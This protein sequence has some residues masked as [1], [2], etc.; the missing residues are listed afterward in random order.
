MHEEIKTLKKIRKLIGWSIK[1]LSK[2]TR[3]S[4]NVILQLEKGE[5]LRNG[6]DFVW[7]II[8][9][10][11][12]ESELRGPL[13]KNKKYD[14][15]VEDD[16]I[17][18]N[19]YSPNL[20]QGERKWLFSEEWLQKNTKRYRSLKSKSPSSEEI[21][22]AITGLENQSYDIQ[23]NNLRKEVNQGHD[24]ISIVNKLRFFRKETD[25]RL[26][27][28]IALA[29]TM[30][31][32]IP[33][34]RRKKYF[35]NGFQPNYNHKACNWL[36]IFDKT[37]NTKGKYATNGGEFFI[38]SLGYFLDYINHDLK[39]IMEWDEEHHFD[40]N[41]NLAERDLIRQQT[42]EKLFPDYKELVGQI[43]TGS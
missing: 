22:A 39:I 37:N 4:C 42:I 26:S 33:D 28:A 32:S 16:K 43:W 14:R 7:A 6:N 5:T 3:L 1:D 31:R 36:E 9:A 23:P 34:A 13:K 29:K 11:K 41:G 12:S 21:R 38:E 27:A 18:L 10:L 19:E 35:K 20:S 25:D 15:K 24:L 8:I 30:A 2:K 40:A 17:D